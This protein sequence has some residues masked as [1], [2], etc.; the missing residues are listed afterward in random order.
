[1]IFWILAAVFLLLVIA[2]FRGESRYRVI[3]AALDDH[4]LTVWERLPLYDWEAEGH[5]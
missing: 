5:L 1:M 3:E 2:Y 4:H